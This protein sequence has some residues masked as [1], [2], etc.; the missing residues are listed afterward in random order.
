MKKHPHQSQRQILKVFQS[1]QQHL[2]R[3]MGLAPSTCENRCRDVSQFLAAVSVRRVKDL[4]KLGPVDLVSYLTARSADYE[5]ASLRGVASSLR[6]FLRF[7]HQQGWTRQSLGVAVPR[8]ATG[9]RNDLPV[10]LSTPQ[11]ESL[12]GSW[13]RRTVEGVR[14]LAIGL[15]L[16]R[17][18]LRAGEVAALRLEDLNW[19]QGTLRL[20]QSKNG[21]QAELP[22]LS[23]VGE[24][25]AGYLRTGRPVCAHR[26]VFLFLKPA[27]P[28]N[29]EAI[30]R[31]VQR[32]LRRCGIE[33]PR[34]GAHLLRH[35]LASHLVQNGASLKEV[36]DVLRHRDLDSASVYAHVDV[37]SLRQLAQ[38]WPKEAAL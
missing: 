12:L 36:A 18:G 31:V 11:L 27:R 17:L 7:A 8:I 24:A 35:T 4:D 33:V 34:P 16:A 30:S 9:A 3:V 25:I 10:Y 6:D 1:Y 15:C 19:R 14:D 20:S 13:D 29:S 2:R 22:L 32:A 38:P 26:E 37:A 5:P 23:E 28:M 21:S